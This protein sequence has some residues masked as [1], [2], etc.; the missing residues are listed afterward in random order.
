MV[1]D[2]AKGFARALGSFLLAV[3]AA[4]TEDRDT[5]GSL[6]SEIQG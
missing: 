4:L 6:V 2:F 5:C 3:G 1:I